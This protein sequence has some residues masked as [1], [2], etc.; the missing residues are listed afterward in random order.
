MLYMKRF[1]Y[2]KVNVWL[3]VLLIMGVCL[4]SVIC[5]KFIVCK[6]RQ[7]GI[8]LWDVMASVSTFLAVAA[9]SMSYHQSQRTRLQAS[10]DAVFAQLLNGL[11]S[12]E[13]FFGK[14]K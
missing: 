14:S 2:K 3:A 5:C 8:S 10:F 7:V 6:S 11:L 4:L 13:C 12:Y 9:A 1:E